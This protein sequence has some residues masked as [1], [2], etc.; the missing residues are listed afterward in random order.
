MRKSVRISLGFAAA[1]FSAFFIGCKEKPSDDKTVRVGLLHSFTGTMAISE[2]S[3][4]DS[5]LLAIKEINEA[6]GVLGRQIEVVKEDGASN[7]QI[8]AERARKLLQEDKVATV[9]G[10]WTSDS[11]KAVKPIFE[12]LFG[13]LWYPVQYEGMEASPNIM[14]MGAAPNQ[15]IIPAVDYCAENIGTKMFLIG[16]DYVFPHSANRIIKAQLVEIGGTCLGEEYTPM[17]H[18]DYSAIVKKI[19]AM[20]PDVIL[21]SLNGDSNIAFFEELKKNGIT[22]EEI[23]V[24]SFS[25][26]EEEI[27][28]MNVKNLEG[29]L[30]AWNYFET[31]ST[32]QNEKFVAA[33]KSAYGKER[34]TGDPVEA[35]Y[36]AVYLWAEAC[37]KAGTFDVEAVRM[38]AKGLHFEA[39][40]GTVT[41][42]GGNQHLYK[43]VRIG[44]ISEDG[45]IH[46][47]WATPSAIKPDPYLSTYPWARGL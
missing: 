39:P 33:Y 35:G 2:T 10:C 31:T 47:I 16:S 45:L 32:P 8:F 26:S 7:A 30:V 29:H 13:L 42:D 4:Y 1:I 28:K 24:M 5:E 34:M 14:Y 40:E 3:V 37:K 12:E 36:N 46:E 27:A 17:G 20:N 25:I 22:S 11:R 23:P 43:Q 38:A 21:N 41:I 9:F 6:G 15:Q 18:T 19:K 44:K